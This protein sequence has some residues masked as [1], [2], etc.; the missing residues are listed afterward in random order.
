MASTGRKTL[1]THLSDDELLAELE[2]RKK[3]QQTAPTPL[4][5]PDFSRL[6]TMVTREVKELAKPDGYSKDF[7]HYIF[8]EVL[9]AIYGKDIWDW[10]SKGPGNREYE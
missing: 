5:T 1:L 7:S 4:Q 2:A 10:W 9:T 8:E 3:K 6:V